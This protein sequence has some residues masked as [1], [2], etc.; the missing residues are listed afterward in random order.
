MQRQVRRTTPASSSTTDTLDPTFDPILTSS[1]ALLA[2]SPVT[3]PPMSWNI[4]KDLLQAEDVGF[5]DRNFQPLEQEHGKT[6]LCSVVNAGK[7]A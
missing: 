5:F 3:Q 6:I 1:P 2:A 7:H 4:Y